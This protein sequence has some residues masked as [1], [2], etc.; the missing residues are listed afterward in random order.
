ML[1]KFHVPSNP[2]LQQ[3]T[4]YLLKSTMCM[5]SY[6]IAMI[7][8]CTVFT[9]N[10]Q[11]DKS[12]LAPSDTLLYR[13]L[14]IDSPIAPSSN[15]KI[16]SQL[17]RYLQRESRATLPVLRNS[18]I[19]TISMG[20]NRVRNSGDYYPDV[21]FPNFDQEFEDLQETAGSDIHWGIPLI[22]NEQF[23]QCRDSLLKAFD[24][25]NTTMEAR[26]AEM[27][28]LIKRLELFSTRAQTKPLFFVD[29]QTKFKGNIR[30]YVKNLYKK[31][32]MSNYDRLTDFL[33]KPRLK[34]IQ[35]DPGVQMS[36]SLA[37]YELWIKDVRE[38][39]VK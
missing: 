31:S 17:Y 4:I 5:K 6:I 10:A 20:T 23:Y 34:K 14:H 22:R 33:K 15:I 11:C 30:K 8:C 1:L 21:H 27:E 25:Q 37:L 16:F 13:Q 7:L 26:Q 18:G 35:T 24:A 9:A 2:R 39:K 29:I 19:N 12:S 3:V 32:M 36:I 28:D 38:G